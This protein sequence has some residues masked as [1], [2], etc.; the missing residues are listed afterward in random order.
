M[1]TS[2]TKKCLYCGEQ[3]IPKADKEG[4]EW[5][6]PN[7]T[8]YAHK[9]CAD[10]HIKVVKPKPKPK[11][12]PV[13]PQDQETKDLNNLKDYIN[14][15]YNSNVN[16]PLVMKQ[17]KTYKEEQGF[18]YVGMLKSLIYFYEVQHHEVDPSITKG[19]G[20]ILYSYKPAYD[21][22]YDLWLAQNANNNKDVKA[23]LNKFKEI[24]IKSPERKI[25]IKLFDL[26]VEE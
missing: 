24:S 17:I 18:T 25:P 8:R 11:P 22:Y 3:F 5:V 1:A 2:L 10:N 12:Q 20:I 19:V 15:L 16:W 9:T 7:K 6:K 4:I 21:Y 13:L 23:S 14:K 26:G